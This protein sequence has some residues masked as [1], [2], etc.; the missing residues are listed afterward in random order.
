MTM[1]KILIFL[2]APFALMS[3]EEPYEIKQDEAEANI[4][5][6]GLLTNNPDLQFIKISKTAD[7]YSSGHTPRVT[8]ATVTVN[9]DAG[10]TIEYIHNPRNHADS[11]GYY[12]PADGFV[13][14][15]GRTYKLA[16]DVAGVLYEAQ[17]KLLPITPI[18]SLT[19]KLDEEEQADPEDEGRFYEVLLFTTEPQDREDFYLFKFYRN[20]TLTY[21]NDSDIY[22]S[23]DKL[24]AEDIEGIA[25]PSYFALNDD[26]RVEAYSLSR[27]GYVFYNDLSSLLNNDSGGMFGP[28]PST[29][30][31]NLSNNAFG[32]FQVSAVAMDDIRVE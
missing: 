7:F 23:D 21:D 3:C 4:V 5:I 25:V 27:Q 12:F 2:I 20:D 14:V 11:A 22:Y 10:N 15:I 19:I 30:R 9:D 29:P 1:K 31:T 8:D 13:G 28:I 24:L 32:F 6:E 17:D 16:V 18:D 26:V